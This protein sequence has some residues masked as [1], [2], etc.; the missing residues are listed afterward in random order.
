MIVQSPLKRQDVRPNL[1]KVEIPPAGKRKSASN[2]ASKTYQKQKPLSLPKLKPWKVILASLCI[3][4][5]G[6]LY[7]T[8]V[9]ATQNLLNEVRL[10]E[11]DYNRARA[12]YDGFKLQYDRMIGPAEIYEKAE[13]RGFINGGPADKVII[14]KN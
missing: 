13:T 4:A 3:G 11:A 1:R 6:L 12:K 9:F 8:H 5:A 14:I 10:L 2:G 7:L